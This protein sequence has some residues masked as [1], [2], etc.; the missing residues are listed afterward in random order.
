MEFE[1]SHSADGA[2]N[3]FVPLIKVK[4]KA[5]LKDGWSDVPEGGD[6]S[7]R[8]FPIEVTLR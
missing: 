3:S 1:L 2:D 5:K 7:F 4:G 6:P 8:F